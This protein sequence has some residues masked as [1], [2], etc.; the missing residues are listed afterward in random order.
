MNI[1][2]YSKERNLIVKIKGDIDHHTSETIKTKIEKEFSVYNTKN[3]IFDFSG[4]E[5]MDSSGIGMIIGRYKTVKKSG[6]EVVIASLSD[7]SKKLIELCGLHK[8]LEC[9]EDVE[10]AIESLK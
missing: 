1:E 4:L 3:L 8:L 7:V 5:F 2:I 9:Y 10:L 6:G